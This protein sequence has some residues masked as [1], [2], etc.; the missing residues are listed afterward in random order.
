MDRDSKIFVNEIA[1]RG[2]LLW[3]KRIQ[4][5]QDPLF[6]SNNIFNSKNLI[7]LC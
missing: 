7:L 6:I 4:E 1:R 3:R 5:N 2:V